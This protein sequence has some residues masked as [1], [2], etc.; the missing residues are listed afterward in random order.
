LYQGGINVTTPDAFV[1][2]TF[3][4]SGDTSSIISGSVIQF[5]E[6]ITAVWTGGTPNDTAILGVY[7]MV[8]DVPVA[9]G[10]LLPGVPGAHFVGRVPFTYDQVALSTSP[11]IVTGGTLTTAIIDMR[12]YQGCMIKIRASTIT[13]TPAAYNPA[14]INMNWY[15]DSG[16]TDLVFKDSYEIFAQ[17]VGGTFVCNNGHLNVHDIVHGPFLRI[18]VY[19]NGPDSITG[20]VEVNGTSRSF[21]TLYMQEVDF[22]PTPAQVLWDGVLHNIHNDSLGPGASVNFAMKMEPGNIAVKMATATMPYSFQFT[23]G[24]LP[25][26]ELFLIPASTTSRQNLIFPKRSVV[27]NVKNTGAGTD[28]YSLSVYR[29]MKNL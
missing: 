6:A 12:A 19:N 21:G 4:G 14:R 26:V 17:Q 15:M 29:E 8:S 7:G 22:Q 28:V 16:A 20:S 25:E 23:I 24:S 13:V 27:V 2:S 10:S 18:N 3:L 9:T 1:D 11:T 5:G